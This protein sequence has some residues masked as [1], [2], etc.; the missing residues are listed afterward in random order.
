MSNPSLL[1]ITMIGLTCVRSYSH[2]TSPMLC[3][4]QCCSA[5]S[6]ISLHYQTIV[7]EVVP[8]IIHHLQWL[9]VTG[10]KKLWEIIFVPK[11]LVLTYFLSSTTIKILSWFG[12]FGRIFSSIKSPRNFLSSDNEDKR[13]AF[14]VFKPLF[15]HLFHGLGKAT[16][17]YD[18][19]ILSFLFSC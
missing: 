10:C 2:N 1:H 14:V 6:N 4:W 15:Q 5:S 12:I 17:R 16:L 13:T 9:M 11:H 18:Y 8:N 7:L 19:F 3:S